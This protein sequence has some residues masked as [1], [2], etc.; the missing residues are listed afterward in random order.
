MP[1]EPSSGRRTR[2]FIAWFK[3]G[4]P[5]ISRSPNV[6]LRLAFACHFPNANRQQV[7]AAEGEGVE[8]S[9]LALVRVRA[10]CHRPLACPSVFSFCRLRLSGRTLSRKRQKS[11]RQDLNLRSPAPEAGALPG[12]ATRRF[13]SQS[14]RQD[15][16]L[17][18]PAPKAGALASLRYSE[19]GPEGL[20]PS[21]RWLRAR[22]A[23][24]NTLVP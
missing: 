18:S 14:P 7:C 16:N 9:R 22:D 20:E 3:A 2:T 10:G 24:A 15:S 6:C 23:A 17:R 21:R 19:V 1:T 11:P 8:P 13:S 5:T 12:Y 4:Q